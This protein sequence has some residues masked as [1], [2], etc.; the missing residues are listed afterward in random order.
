[1]FMKKIGGEFMK[2]L[3]IVILLQM[4]CCEINP[5]NCFGET[6]KNLTKIK[7]IS[8]PQPM[9]AAKNN[10]E[11]KNMFADI[12]EDLTSFQS[13]DV[14]ATI[15]KHLKEKQKDYK[16]YGFESVKVISLANKDGIFIIKYVFS[17]DYKAKCFFFDKKGNLTTYING[18]INMN[19]HYEVENSNEQKNVR[20]V[21]ENYRI[22]GSGIEM[23]FHSTGFPKSFTKIA[24]NRLFGRQIEWNDKGEV[25]SDIDL[26]IPEPWAGAP[27]NEKTEK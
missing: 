10:T 14:E 23:T 26:D 1:M 9:S 13:G 4:L 24:K 5:V 20:N 8:L 7:L 11:I 27:K 19:K 2:F 17:I 22:D 16:K 18:Q 21:P 15:K 25:L 12:Q 6:R 3:C